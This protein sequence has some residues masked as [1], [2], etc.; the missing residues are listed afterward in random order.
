MKKRNI[1]YLLKNNRFKPKNYTAL[2]LFY[3][4]TAYRHWPNAM[5]IWSNAQID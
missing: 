1:L 4:L 3:L 5:R 2:F